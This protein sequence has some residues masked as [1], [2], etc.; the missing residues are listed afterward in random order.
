MRDRLA[1][2]ESRE[3][4]AAGQR[5][6][7]A[8]Q[9]QDRHSG[10]EDGK[11]HRKFVVARSTLLQNSSQIP[12]NTAYGSNKACNPVGQTKNQIMPVLSR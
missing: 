11:T 6:A 8:R 1:S 10:K 3:K 7:P 5:A 4:T 9:L 12:G 2:S